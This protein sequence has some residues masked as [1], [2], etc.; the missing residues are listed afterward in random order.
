MITIKTFVFNPFQENTYIVFDESGECLIV[1]PGCH[2]SHEE[3]TLFAFIELH[4]LK[5]VWHLYTHCH[6]DHILGNVYVYDTWGLKPAM[7]EDSLPVFRDAPN[8]AMIYGIENCKIVDRVMFLKEG[9][10]IKFGTSHL[11]VLHTPGHVDGHLCFVS[12]EEKFVIVGDV[13]FKDSI[14]RTDLPTGDYDLL[15][16]SIRTKLYTLAP[17]FVVYPGHGPE[18]AIGYE[19]AN[20]PFVAG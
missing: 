16:E 10:T 5:P 7:H 6:I 19:K 11:D 14:G 12:H 20:N 15:A 9:D 3:K 13:L 18:T 4:R 17:D 8:H 1:D 2:G